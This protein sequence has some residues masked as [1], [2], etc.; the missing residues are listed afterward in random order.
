MTSPTSVAPT[1]WNDFHNT[2]AITTTTTMI[3][4]SPLPMAPPF[5]LTD[6]RVRGGAVS[7]LIGLVVCHG[8]V[9]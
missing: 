8:I 3:T 1:E 6:Q 7:V 4:M 2:N 9:Q 5:R